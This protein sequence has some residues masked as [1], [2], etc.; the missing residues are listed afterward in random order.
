[1]RAQQTSAPSTEIAAFP[2]YLRPRRKCLGASLAVYTHRPYT[3]GESWRPRRSR[4]PLREVNRRALAL[5]WDF[6]WPRPIPLIRPRVFA[7]QTAERERER[8]RIKVRPFFGDRRLTAAATLAAARDPQS[9]GRRVLPRVIFP[10]FCIVPPVAAAASE[11]VSS[12]LGA[13]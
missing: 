2:L 5:P 4:A 12:S 13:R 8:R 1:M 6:D 9:A 7:P 10:D 11:R 3:G